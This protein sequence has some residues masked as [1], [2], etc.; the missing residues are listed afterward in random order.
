MFPLCSESRR[1]VGSCSDWLTGRRRISQY[2][3]D[4]EL[5]PILR[6]PH[7]TNIDNAMV[8]PEFESGDREWCFVDF[9]GVTGFA[10][11]EICQGDTVS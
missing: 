11:D 1:L 7:P 6:L 4:S 9:A 10:R 2:F 3:K 5:R 8:V